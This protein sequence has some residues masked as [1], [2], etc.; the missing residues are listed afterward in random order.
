MLAAVEKIGR[1]E[2]IFDLLRAHRNEDRFMQGEDRGRDPRHLQAGAH[3]AETASRFAALSPE[4]RRVLDG[5]LAPAAMRKAARRPG[6]RAKAR[7][8][9]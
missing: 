5:M 8:A 7:K 3:P 4:S 6:A 1:P 9:R 2:E